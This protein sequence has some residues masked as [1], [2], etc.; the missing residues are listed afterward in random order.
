MRNIYLVVIIFISLLITS[1]G[2]GEQSTVFGGD[3]SNPLTQKN[4]EPCDDSNPTYTKILDNDT[5]VNTQKDTIVNI[6]HNTN[7]QK[8]VCVKSGSA[9]LLREE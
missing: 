3:G 6:I 8:K 1:C 7:K 5:L 9:H 2:S 4:V